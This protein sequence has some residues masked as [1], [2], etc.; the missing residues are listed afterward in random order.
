[1]EGYNEITE[2]IS[3]WLSI[4]KIQERW[5][6]YYFTR[7]E[8]KDEGVRLK[9]KDIIDKVK[10]DVENKIKETGEED[11]MESDLEQE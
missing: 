11:E 5:G 4:I 2:Q 8:I 9:Y 10:D 6:I 3:C 1:M 7:R